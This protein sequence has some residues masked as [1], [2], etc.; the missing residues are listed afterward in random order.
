M[1][2]SKRISDLRN[3]KQLKQSD[4]AEILGLSQS[5][6]SRIENK[7][8]KLTIEQLEKIAG[9]LG[10]SVV[11]LLTGDTQKQV[12]SKDIESLR[13][14][15]KEL[16][17]ITKIQRDFILSIKQKFAGALNYEF[18]YTA[19]DLGLLDENGDIIDEQG[20]AKVFFNDNVINEVFINN[21]IDENE[22]IY[23]DWLAYRRHL[24]E[25]GKIISTMFSRLGKIRHNEIDMRKKLNRELKEDNVNVEPE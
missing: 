3:R 2:I 15:V 7:A 12:D 8:D 19:V 21:L 23:K 25:Q 10:V 14:R 6:Y 22:Q 5:S 4:F 16:E 24:N 11:E 9:A 20:V 18:Y 1:N 17:E 13:K